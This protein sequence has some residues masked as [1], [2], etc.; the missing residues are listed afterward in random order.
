MIQQKICNGQDVFEMLP[1]AYDFQSLLS[2]MGP[3]PHSSSLTGLPAAVLADQ[4]RFD[5][6]LPGGCKREWSQTS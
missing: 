2:Q 5:Y 1:E 6:L 4:N 3:I